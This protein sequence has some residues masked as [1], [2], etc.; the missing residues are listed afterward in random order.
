[1]IY[2]MIGGFLFAAAFGALEIVGILPS[3]TMAWLACTFFFFLAG[4]AGYGKYVDRQNRRSAE[5]A[6]RGKDNLA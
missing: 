3:K 5:K 1:M 6:R 4:L 2:A